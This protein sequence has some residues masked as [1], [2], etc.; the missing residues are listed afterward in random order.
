LSAEKN[1]NILEVLNFL[2]L[3]SELIQHDELSFLLANLINNQYVYWFLYPN[4]Y[5]IL[6][7]IISILTNTNNSVLLNNLT[8]LLFQI[9]TL[10]NTNS[11]APE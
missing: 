3:N 4:F 5:N 1:R 9:I 8:N 7:R 11:D 10:L 6:S 2:Q